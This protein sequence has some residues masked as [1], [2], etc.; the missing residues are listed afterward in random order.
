ME[1]LLGLIK[2]VK[3][4]GALVAVSFIVGRVQPCKERAHAGFDFKGDTD[5]T[6]ERTERLSR[7]DVLEQA[8]RLF[9][10]NASF[11]VSG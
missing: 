9:A 2:G 8:A 10:P 3:M 5:G 7:D 11:S 6:R 1:E 4:N